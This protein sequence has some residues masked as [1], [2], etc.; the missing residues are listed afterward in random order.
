MLFALVFLLTAWGLMLF[1]RG[2]GGSSHHVALLWPWPH[3][4]IAAAFAE[5]TRRLGRAGVPVLVLV[6]ALVCG[7]AALSTNVHL[8]QFIRNGAAGSW[9]D[10]VYGLSDYLGSEK[11]RQVV[12][13]DWG[14]FEPLRLL[15]R[16]RLPL[17][18][19][20][21]PLQPA[22]PS[23]DDVRVFREMIDQP[24]RVF[25][26]YTDTHEQFAGVN[27]RLRQMLDA[28]GRRR[29]VLKVIQDSNG[30][31]VYE[32][33]AIRR[34]YPDKSLEVTTWASQGTSTGF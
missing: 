2:A 1:G 22:P 8:S 17:V 6:T 20:A 19:G 4:L 3:L 16:G 21:D 27:E 29:E 14:I 33:F 30:R 12:V 34:R 11:G 15:H 9:T 25:V 10:A 28:L 24:N 7:K 32:V 13:L 31:P 23:P 18:W 26:S 5:A